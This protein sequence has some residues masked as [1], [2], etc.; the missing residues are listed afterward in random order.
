MKHLK[1]WFV[2]GYTPIQTYLWIVKFEL[3]VFC[4]NYDHETHKLMDHGNH[5]NK[6]HINLSRVHRLFPYLKN[7]F[8]IHIFIPYLGVEYSLKPWN[9][10]NSH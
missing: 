4:C 9:L 6:N 2:I 5:P 8:G 10:G 1:L 3:T 7:Y